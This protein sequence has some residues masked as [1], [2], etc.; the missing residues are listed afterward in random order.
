MTFW[1]HFFRLLPRRPIPALAALYW[2]VTRRRLRARNRL[3]AA[4]ADLRFPYQLWIERTERIE[5]RTGEFT[6][7]MRQWVL[8]PG[9]HVI[10]YSGE[11]ATAE[12][13]DRSVKSVERQIYE[14]AALDTDPSLEISDVIATTECHYVVPLRVGDVL[15]EAALFRFGEAFQNDPTAA[16]I[17]GDEDGL[18]TCGNRIR[19][20]FKPRWNR[21]MFLAQDYLSS[22]VAIGTSHARAALATNAGGDL[23]DLLLTV[24]MLAGH[25]IVHVPHVLCHVGARAKV[26]DARRI[27]SVGKNVQT[28]GASVTAGPFGTVKVV[29][30]LPNDLPLVSI[31]VPTKDK[32][33][34]LRPCMEGVLGR[35]DYPNFQVLI[36][37]NSSVEKATGEYLKEVS[38]D[39]RVRVLP[40]PKHYNFSAINNFAAGHACGSFLCLLNNDTEVVTPGWLTE[41]MRYGLRPEI[42]AVGAKLLYEDGSIQHAGV[43]VGIGGAAGHAHRFLPA[44][45][46]GYFH[47]AH[48][49]QFVTAVTAAC[50]VVEKSK[51]EA[52]GGFDEKDLAVAFNDVDLCLKLQAAGWHNVYVPHAV[53]LHHE[54]KSRGDDLS[55][56]NVDRFKRELTILQKRWDTSAYEDPLHNPNL[57]RYS[58]TFV[59]RL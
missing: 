13:L 53:L 20:W 46:P 48:V 40:Y 28:L 33:S 43:V 15:S 49:A 30:P 44:D 9:F 18:G 22:A 38:E 29:W 26:A 59:C 36:V 27:R 31:I 14:A 41:M 52:V 21:E 8:S 35:T 19:P 4:S 34:L 10:L 25:S 51:F 17:Y 7:T 54:S 45:Q 2:H 56:P 6:S 50:L 1:E 3:R 5:H 24:T 32:L 23:D 58:E 11:N 39:P 16:I 55:R 57:D 37:D 12:Q 42:G 47:M